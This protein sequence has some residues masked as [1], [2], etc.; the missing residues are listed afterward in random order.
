[1]VVK[2][3]TDCWFSR[4]REVRRVQRLARPLNFSLLLPAI[5]NTLNPPLLLLAPRS[6]CALLDLIKS[7]LSPTGLVD[8]R[9]ETVATRGS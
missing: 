2:K 9:V 1:M 5:R 8:K 7:A 6:E 3:L 4:S